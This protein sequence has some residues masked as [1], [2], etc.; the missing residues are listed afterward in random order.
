MAKTLD[1]YLDELEIIRREITEVCQHLTKEDLEKF[2]GDN[3]RFFFGWD[4]KAEIKINIL[5]VF[6]TF[7]LMTSDVKG[8]RRG[9]LYAGIAI[10]GDVVSF[11]IPDPEK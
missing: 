6:A 8:I 11:V 9:Q 3:T 7:A 1:Q 2:L 5:T 10:S 4:V